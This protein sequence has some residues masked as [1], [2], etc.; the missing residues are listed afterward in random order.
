[1]LTDTIGNLFD[2]IPETNITEEY[3]YNHPGEYPVYSGQTEAQGILGYIDSFNQHLPCVTFTT[4]GVGAGKLFYR[5]G[6]YT[7]GRNCMGL[8]PKKIY[9]DKI[10]LKWFSYSFQNTF[11]RLRIGDTDGQRSLNKLLL[12]RQV[13]TI[14]DIE[15]Q[16]RQLLQYG[17]LELA[18]QRVDRL[19][20]S[21]QKISN[22]SR[23]YPANSI[24]AEG[25]FDDFVQLIGGNSGLTEEFIYSNLPQ[26]PSDSIQILTSST[27]ERTSMGFISRY[28]KPKGKKL[29]IFKAPSIIVA[30]NG[31]AGNMTYISD[32]EFTTNDHAYVLA[33]K[34]EWKDSINLEWLI[35]E[36]QGLFY[37]LVTSRSDNATFN[38]EYAERQLIK[39]PKIDL[40]DSMVT[41]LSQPKT[42]VSKSNEIKSKILN[43]LEH[44]IV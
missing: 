13:I 35:Y 18:L 16:N 31:Y 34:S 42:L 15:I 1:M 10:N 12:E 36:Y 3:L 5:R 44:T 9:T 11:Y 8:R 6:K 27:L 7:I 41:K 28:A 43:L 39:I 30:R 4:Y 17:H 26:S 20:A 38:K 2:F 33:P 19:L 29:K 22:F 23:Q 14:P 37:S 32:G 25:K 40:Q 21:L 24:V